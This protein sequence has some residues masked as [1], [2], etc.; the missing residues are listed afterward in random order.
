MNL[1]L[2]DKRVVI[3]GAAKGIGY[4]TAKLFLEEGAHVVF[5]ARKEGQGNEALEEL[6]NVNRD[7]N[8]FLYSGDL[9]DKK[10]ITNCMSFAKEKL[11]GIDILVTNIG[12]GKPEGDPSSK[13]EKERMFT[14]NF[15]SAKKAV[16]EAGSLM[17]HNG[18]VVVV[19]SIAGREPIGAPPAYEEAK[20]ALLDFVK[21]ESVSFAKRGIRINS[22][23]PGNVKFKDGR[24]EEILKND[25]TVEAKV[26]QKVPM[27]R[28]GEPKEI[29]SIIVFLASSCSSFVTGACWVVD[30]GQSKKI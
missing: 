6:K 29:A 19:S 21:G 30:G 1:E 9:T 27:Q 2:R 3:T 20:K 11:G 10:E 28:F 25:P 18:S 26:L 14:I 7:S 17:E 8:V 4:A 12:S 22:V 13:E 23:A 16:Q 15:E 24:W 5:S